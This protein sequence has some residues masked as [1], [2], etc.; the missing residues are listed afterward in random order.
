MTDENISNH[1]PKDVAFYTAV[2]QAWVTTRL[3]KDR[4]L[5]NLSTAGIGLL[6][7]LLT[8]VGPSSHCELLLYG[9]AG[10]CFAS[11]IVVALLVFDRNSH[12]LEEVIKRRKDDDDAKLIKLDLLLLMLFMAGVVLTGAIGILSGYNRI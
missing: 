12:H 9:L 6:V 2:V 3:E 5:L 7:T 8:T 10:V 1:D 11:A 4:A